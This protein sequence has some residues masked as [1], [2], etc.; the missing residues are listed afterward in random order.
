MTDELDRLF[1]R[2]N[3]A[4]APNTIA[5]YRSDFAN[6]SN[7][8]KLR[9]ISPFKAS[10]AQLAD[11]IEWA[12]YIECQAQ[13]RKCSSVERRVTC[14]GTILRLSNLPDI[15]HEAECVLALKRMRRRKGSAPRQAVPLTREVL[16][17]LLAVCTADT[18][19]QRDRV[20]LLLGYETMRRRS[21]LCRFCFEDIEALP[22]GNTGL[23]LRLSKTDQYGRGK[24]IP[25]SPRLLA[26]LKDWREPCGGQG[27]ILRSVHKSGSV[28][29]RL[30]PASL[31]R[32]LKELQQLA[33]LDLSGKLSGHSFR[34]GAALDLLEQ[35]E[36][37]PK[38]MLRG[39]WQSESTVIR[40]LREWQALESIQHID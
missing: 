31:C 40:Y 26:A 8:C 27:Y 12:D 6:Y 34:V 33:E 24:L 14:I 20:M 28:G 13:T 25:I 22:N 16:K 37:L 10:A 38:I 5:A 17:P 32:R 18:R 21:E 39:S 35:G 1:A 36:P 11:Y 7:W 23:R 2:F 3:G 29:E 9:D 15:T 30:H 4:F 19:G